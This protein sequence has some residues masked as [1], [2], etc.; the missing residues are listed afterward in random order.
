M[1]AMPNLERLSGVPLH[2]LD[3]CR[4]LLAWGTDKRLKSL[5]KLVRSH[6]SD[7]CD[8]RG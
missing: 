3:L 6:L 8:I 7:E 4:F 1:P 2:V 5:W